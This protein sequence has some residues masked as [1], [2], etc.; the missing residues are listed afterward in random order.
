M[1]IHIIGGGINGLC[2]AYYLRK[3][4]YKV[5]V[6]DKNFSEGGTSYGNAGMI[7]PSHFIPMASPGVIAQGLKWMFDPKSPFYIRPRMDM[8]LIQWLWNFYRSCTKENVIKSQELIWNYNE[9]SKT[10]YKDIVTKE[11]FEV[12]YNEK[13]L[14]MLFKS[15]KTKKEELEMADHALKLG[16][17]AKF[18]DG[19]GV[20][21]INPDTRVEVLGGIYFPDDA[22]LYSNA[23]MK[24]M[25]DSLKANGV[26]FKKGSVYRLIK[27]GNKIDRLKFSSGEEI[28]SDQIILT[29]GAWTSELLQTVGV[30]LLLQDGKGYSVTLRD[31]LLKPT[32]PSI[33]TEEKVAITPMGDHL[34][35]TGTLEISG[36][37]TKINHK[38]VKGFLEAVPK[39]F[40]DITPEYPE[41]NKIW[42]GYRPLSPDGVPYVGRLTSLNNVIIGTGHGMMGM[43]LGP[44]TGKMISNIIEGRKMDIDINLLDPERFS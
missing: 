7:V 11:N 37:T 8:A 26:K 29:A 10:L 15:E 44:A 33:L 41:G 1:D 42:T 20:Q 21:E 17:D 12:D 32:I 30:K 38:R 43:S 22:H 14:L 13:G 16:V 25:K 28:K 39:Y 19:P 31:Q 2:S 5:T 6:V 23:F 3:S 27:K 36:K 18:M 4:G 34:R 35:I 24:E 40:P 9:W